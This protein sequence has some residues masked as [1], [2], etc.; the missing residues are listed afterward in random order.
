MGNA[1][2][3]RRPWIWLIAAILVVVLLVAFFA[4]LVSPKVPAD[5]GKTL[6]AW[7]EELQ[8]AQQNYSDPERWK[9]IETASAAIRAIGTNALPFVMADIRVR[10]TIKDRYQL[11]RYSTPLP[12]TPAHKN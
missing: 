9:K 5:Q 4:A 11:A 12:E 8:K 6:Y 3:R 2:S 10:V 7:A 1:P